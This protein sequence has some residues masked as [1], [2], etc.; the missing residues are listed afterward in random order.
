MCACVGMFANRDLCVKIGKCATCAYM[1]VLVCLR[2]L[3][4]VYMRKHPCGIVRVCGRACICVGG[5]MCV[6]AQ[7][8][9]RVCVGARVRSCVYA[10]VYVC[11]CAYVRVCLLARVRV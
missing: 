4:R 9:M 2:E 8:S 1:F 5:R 6:Y 10:Y 7:V 11:V 3:T